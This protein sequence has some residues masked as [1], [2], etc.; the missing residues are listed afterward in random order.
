[1]RRLGFWI[2]A[3]L[4]AAVLLTLW[5]VWT[6]RLSHANYALSMQLEAER[7]RSFTDM[8]HH[9]EQIQALL[10]KGLV[11]G[12]ARQNMRY[13]SD[14]HHHAMAA[15]DRFTSLPL[16]AQFSAVTGKFLQQTGDFAVSLLR[17]EAAGREMT[18]Q[19]RAELSRLR[20]DATALSAQLQGIM[21]EYNKGGVRWAPPVQL[22]WANLARGPELLQKPATGQQAPANLIGRGWEQVTTAM[23]QLPVM[24][25]NGPFS[26]HVQQRNP[27]VSGPPV[28]QEEAQRRAMTAIPGGGNYQVAAVEGVGGSLPAYSFRLA[29]G[30]GAV[31]GQAGAPGQGAAAGQAQYTA[32]V[33]VTRNGGHLAQFLNM[34]PAG[35][36]TLDLTRARQ[37]GQRYLEGIGYPGMTPTYGQV[38][39]G[40]ATIAY[41]FRQGDVLIYP[42]QIKLK[43]ALD[44]GE[45]LGVDA[46]QFL[47]AHHTRDLPAPAV[48]AQEA[49]ARLNG[50]LAVQR[51][52]LTLIPDLAGTGELLAY[53]F[54]G[55]ADGETF[56]VYINA[57]TGFEEQIQQL[58]ETDGGTFAL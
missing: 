14:V 56:L 32:V 16:P 50:G 3:G 37:M 58:I 18:E 5:G 4:L 44:N 31:A 30:Q 47:M 10:A 33:E 22:S 21:A 20:R 43:I 13:M 51:V 15:V 54:L 41:A 6:F 23:E 46:R 57:M 24:V 26:D 11:T 28:T 2:P 36:P 17:H 25:Y 48:T 29:P 38:E 52:Q 9:V 42:D 40:M 35:D 49:R 45:I 55:T 8:A 39:D 53:E 1:M 34:R 27:A 7:Q 12:N 19:Q